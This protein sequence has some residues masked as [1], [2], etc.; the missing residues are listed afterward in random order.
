MQR[1]VSMAQFGTLYH[2]TSS[3]ADSEPVLNST[4]SR[5]PAH[6]QNWG[7]NF[8]TTDPYEALH[9]A[10]AAASADT[11]ADGVQRHPRVFQVEQAEADADVEVDP[12]T[13][14]GSE[15]PSMEDALELA[16]YG[17]G[18]SLRTRSALNVVGG[19]VPEVVLD[20]RARGEI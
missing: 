17:Y 3:R 7:Y 8:A 1:N 14:D 12:V 5:Y 20:K 4:G 2:G 18:V 6:R 9:Y 13:A 15:P 16:D 11:K 19:V 10:E